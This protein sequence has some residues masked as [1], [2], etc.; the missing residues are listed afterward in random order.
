MGGKKGGVT[1][2]RG[3]SKDE[4]SRQMKAVRAQALGKKK[5]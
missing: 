5:A 2:W 1:R 4:R 3:V